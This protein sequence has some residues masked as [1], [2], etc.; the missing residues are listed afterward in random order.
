MPSHQV[1]YE[2]FQDKTS[3][4]VNVTND[5]LGGRVCGLSDQWF[6]EATN[7]IKDTPPVVEVRFVATGRWYDGWETRRHNTEPSDW[8]TLQLGVNSAKLYGCEVDTTFFSGNHAPAISVEGAVIHNTNEL[9]NA[10][11]EPI[12]DKHECGPSQRH[13]FVRDAATETAYTHVRLHMYP[14][15]GIA[16]FRMYGEPVPVF[17]ADKN[18]VIDMASVANGGVAIAC[19]DQHFSSADN[20]L[21]PGRGL[22]MSDGWETARSRSPGH[23]DWVIVKLG[24]PTLV[25]HVLVDTAFFLGNYPQYIE[26]QAINAASTADVSVESA[27]WKPL[28][29]RTKTGPNQEH[30]LGGPLLLSA[31][32]VTHVKLNIIP[33]GGVKRLRVFGRRA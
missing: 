16:R 3:S 24:A 15:G 10:V 1:S 22:D 19:S 5:R 11:W 8:V 9:E 6:A 17:P 4:Y 33:D 26:V 13:F 32:P 29:A 27:G 18:Q 2:E 7:L 25:D 28:V 12:I 30:A 21:L 14:D 23:I 31:E 20:L